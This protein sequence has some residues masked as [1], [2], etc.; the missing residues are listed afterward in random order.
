M[1][2]NSK[3]ALLS[4]CALVT[5]CTQTSQH[6]TDS[7]SLALLGHEAEEISAQNVEDIPYATILVEYGDN[8]QA[9][10][11][12]AWA[13]RGP[14]RSNTAL[15][16]LSAHNELIVTQSGRVTKT[17]GLSGS[18]VISVISDE[19]DPL[20]AGLD[21]SHTSSQWQ[22]RVSWEPGYHINYVAY[23]EFMNHGQVVKTLP[24]DSRSL[25]YITETVT[26]PAISEQWENEYWLD[27]IDGRVV[28]SI[29]TPV[30][31]MAPLAM[32][33]TKPYGGRNE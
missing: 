19:P 32:T 8:A 7:F 15:K 21:I 12:L 3:L 22:Y 25:V 2:M 20:S 31:G 33:V 30:P 11:V 5:G 26:I 10:M 23:S 1:D 14:E 4:L 16:W 27:P 6:L 9:L 17:S 24:F 18:N 28:S 29:Q 13:E